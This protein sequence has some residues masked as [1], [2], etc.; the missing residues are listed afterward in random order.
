MSA[1]NGPG[2]PLGANPGSSLL[3]TDRDQLN[4][5]Q[6]YRDAGMTASAVFEFVSAQAAAHPRL[7]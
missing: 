7:S 5:L 3:L 6:A 1:G 4:M 2:E